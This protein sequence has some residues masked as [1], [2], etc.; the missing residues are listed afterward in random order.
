M[1]PDIPMTPPKPDGRL[2]S[3]APFVRGGVIAD[4]G[5]DHAY[6][7]VWLLLT[8]RVQGA[9]A[10]D[11]REGPLRT[12]ARTV[13]RYGLSGK[14]SLILADGLA[15]IEKYHPD[16]IIIFGMGGELIASIIEKAK[17]VRDPQIRLILQPMTRRA[18]LREYLLGHGFNVIDEATSEA[19]GRI[20]QTICAEYDGCGGIYN[21]AELLLGRHNIVRGDELTRRYAGQLKAKYRR[22]KSGKAKAG[23]DTSE[24]D[25]VLAALDSL[26]F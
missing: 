11:I 5:T 1:N 2:M 23:L 12:A 15:G 14:I 24:E 6:L 17:W 3:A 4:I 25:E 7:P 22:R 8:G 18:E 19:A 26:G 13:E 10:T 9:V 21:T 16:D 20:Y